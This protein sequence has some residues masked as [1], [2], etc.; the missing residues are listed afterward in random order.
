MAE[1]GAAF[2]PPEQGKTTIDDKMFF[3]PVRLSYE[4]SSLLAK[5]IASRIA[6]RVAGQSVVIVRESLLADFANLNATYLTLQQLR[7]EYDALAQRAAGAIPTP[8]FS[9]EGVKSRGFVKESLAATAA[10]AGVATAAVAAS[11]PLA[12]VVGAALGLVALLRQDVEYHGEQTTVD[13]LA[14]EIALANDLKAAGATR[15]VVPDLTLLPPSTGEDSIQVQLAAVQEARNRAWTEITPLIAELAGLERELDEAT[16]AKAQQEIDALAPR[17]TAARRD[18]DPLALPLERADQKLTDLQTQWA[19]ADQA[20]GMSV[21]ARM[22]RAESLH[23]LDPIYVHA[24][25]IA[26]GGHHRISRNLFRMVFM[27]DGL[28]FQGAAI[29]RWA[30]L[31]RDGSLLEGGILTQELRSRTPR[32]GMSC[33]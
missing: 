3:E 1:S 8:A 26:S 7:N 16:R 27:G 12:P 2:K 28:S 15:V 31:G 20:T 5:R 19:Q 9:K 21:L 6:E 10:V 29:V 11:G 17:I 14:F 4:S 18:L 23:S 22:L 24:A 30:M 25:V 32:V 13:A 33:G